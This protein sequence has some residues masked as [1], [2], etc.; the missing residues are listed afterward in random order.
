[1][2]QFRFTKLKRIRELEE[3]LA[4]EAFA[5]A[6]AKVNKLASRSRE[7]T[8]RYRVYK[9]D[10]IAGKVSWLELANIIKAMTNLKKEMIEAYNNLQEKRKELINA[11]MRL[12]M[13][14]R[15]EEI[16]KEEVFREELQSLQEVLDDFASYKSFIE[17]S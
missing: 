5:E 14:E 13:I 17:K 8:E 10:F 12:K 9:R 2:K 4:E 16:W 3:K 1:M 6:V 11:N 7:L 15:L